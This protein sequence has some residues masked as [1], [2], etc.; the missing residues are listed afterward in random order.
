MNFDETFAGMN[1]DETFW[2]FSNAIIETTC[3]CQRNRPGIPGFRDVLDVF[4]SIRNN[5]CAK[6]TGWNEYEYYPR[7]SVLCS[8]LRQFL[9]WFSP[10][11]RP[12]VRHLEVKKKTVLLAVEKRLRRPCLSV[13]GEK[14]PAPKHQR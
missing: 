7:F 14:G 3:V 12:S 9:V 8:S 11:G 5:V 4:E 10:W 1:F 13:C 6:E 2:T